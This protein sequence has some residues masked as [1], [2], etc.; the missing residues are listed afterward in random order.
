MKQVLK[1]REI[2]ILNLRFGLNGKK[3]K[4]QHEIAS[5]MGI[6]RSYV[7]RI[8]KR[9]LTKIFNDYARKNNILKEKDESLTG[10]DV[11]EPDLLDFE[12]IGYLQFYLNKMSDEDDLEDAIDVVNEQIQED[13][14]GVNDNSNIIYPHENTRNSINKTFKEGDIWLW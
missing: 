6:S 9:A 5:M 11:K 10:E 4:T 14:E 1:D 8:E 13:F 3:P 7:S 12:E 2:D